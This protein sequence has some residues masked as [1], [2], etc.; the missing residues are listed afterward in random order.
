MVSHHESQA[1][2]EQA[3]RAGTSSKLEEPGRMEPQYR[4][5]RAR[6]NS[7]SHWKH[8]C[9]QRRR[10]VGSRGDATSTGSQRRQ[11]DASQWNHKWLHRQTS[12]VVAVA[13]HTSRAQRSS[14]PQKGGIPPKHRQV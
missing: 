10:P 1:P 11:R 9:L 13:A 5:R 6:Q 7:H 12:P 4:P 14:Q 2:I 3:R 8:K